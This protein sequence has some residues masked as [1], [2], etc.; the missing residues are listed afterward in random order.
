MVDCQSISASAVTEPIY[1]YL[2]L[3]LLLRSIHSVYPKVQKIYKAEP[4]VT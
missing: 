2:I 3:V 1:R 4:L